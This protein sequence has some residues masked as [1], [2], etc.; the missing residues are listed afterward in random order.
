MEIKLE[1]TTEGIVNRCAECGDGIISILHKCNPFRNIDLIKH[2][3]RN[4]TQVAR[5]EGGKE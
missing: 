5:K 3:A 1:H 4:G 2:L